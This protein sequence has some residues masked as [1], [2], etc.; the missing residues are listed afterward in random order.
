M[1]AADAIVTAHDASR[2]GRGVAN[3]Y[4][5]SNG[6]VARTAMLLAVANR[7][8]GDARYLDVAADQL[9]VLFGR[10]HYNRSQVTGLGIDPPL[11]PH[12]RPSAADAIANPYPGLLVGGGTT[13]TSWMDDQDMYMVNEVAINWNGALVYALALFLPEGAWPPPQS[14]IDAGAGGDAGTAM[15]APARRVARRRRRRPAHATRRLQL[16]VRAG[17]RRG[18]MDRVG[19]ARPRSSHA[20]ADHVADRVAMRSAR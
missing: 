4:W 19:A 5:G 7:L 11:H 14:E 6:S 20:R 12:H 17:R 15:R 3:Y 8:S 10:N 13:A 1:T 2:Y 16:R 9:A 18:V